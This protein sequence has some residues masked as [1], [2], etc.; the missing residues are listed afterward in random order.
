MFNRGRFTESI[1]FASGK[2]NYTEEYPGHIKP[3]RIGLYQRKWYGHWFYAYWDGFKFGQSSAYAREA[4][5]VR[6]TEGA[7][8]DVVPW[9]GLTRL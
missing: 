3:A 6:D 9:R 8:Q 5:Q 4:Y 1:H 7:A 2:M